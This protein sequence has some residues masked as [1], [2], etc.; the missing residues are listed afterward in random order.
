VTRS[1]D[2]QNTSVHAFTSLGLDW[3]L[4]IFVLVFLVP[5][6]FLFI[7]R[8]KHIPAIVKEESSYSREF[9]MFIGSLVFFLS[10]LF[11][12]SATSLP[13]INKIF[14]TNF[15]IG[16]DTEFPY[17]RIQIFV[18]IIIGIL[19]AVSQYLKYKDTTKKFFLSKIVLPLVVSLTLAILISLFGGI[20][21]DKYGIGYLA[22][23]HLAVFSALFAVIS[24]AMYIVSGLKGKLKLA[25][26]SI[27]HVGFGLMLLGILIS[28]SKK[29]VLSINTTGINLNFGPESKEKSMENVTL[30]KSIKTD[31]GKFHATYVNS[32]STNES[33][34]IMYFKIN[35]QK[36]DSSHN[37]DLYPNL[38]RNTKGSEGFSNN[39]DSKHYW[40]R[41]IF[42][43]ISY[44]DNMDKE[45][46]TAQFKTYPVDVKDTIYYSNGFMVLNKVIANPSN[47]KYKFTPTDTA[48]MADLTVVTKE[49]LEYPAQ[50]V[51]YVRNSQP[52]YIIDTV[53][54]Q[55]L[56]VGFSGLVDGRKIELQVKE[57]AKLTPFVALKVYQ[58]PFINLLWLGSFIMIIGFVISISRRIKLNR[59]IKQV[60]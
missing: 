7:K 30:I 48:L 12:I 51:F 44:A 32:D 40:N 13:V 50:P 31:M 28:S 23:I 2:L 49:G 3:Q 6:L 10:A 4:R 35:F 27:S 19:T 46:D 11:I 8:Y 29:E 41:D 5:A 56:A 53:Y 14:N 45:A 1:G 59:S 39:P 22:A 55:S 24:N 33:G 52:Q 34:T 26:A 21:Y 47:D 18:A 42:S 58:F 43:Y 25:G 57:S 60:I 16:E 37:F 20:N 36:K 15:A 38:I 54:A 17:N 9:W